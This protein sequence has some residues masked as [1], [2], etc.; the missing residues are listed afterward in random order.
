MNPGSSVPRARL[1]A[2]FLTCFFI[3][4]VRLPGNPSTPAQDRVADCE[5]TVRL[6][7]NVICMK[8]GKPL[9]TDGDLELRGPPGDL[10]TP[11][12]ES[13]SG[14]WKEVLPRLCS[15]FFVNRH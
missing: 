1:S 13:F 11:G 10:G 6:E 5:S 9:G 4:L 14:F 2:V 15:L 12:Q 3:L 8:A 7:P